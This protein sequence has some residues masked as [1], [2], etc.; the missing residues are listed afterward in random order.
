MAQVGI[1]DRGLVVTGFGPKR[2]KMLLA[3][4]AADDL[5]DAAW[6]GRVEMHIGQGALVKAA[7]LPGPREISLD[8]TLDRL[9]R[10]A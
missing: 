4:A 8:G 9:V 7:I 2:L 1:A 6:V 5:D 3:L 10:A